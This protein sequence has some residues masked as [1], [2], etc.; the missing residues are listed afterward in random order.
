[1]SLLIG[2]RSHFSLFT[3]TLTH[4]PVTSATLPFFLHD[5]GKRCLH[6]KGY[7]LHLGSYLILKHF[8]HWFSHF[9]LQI[10]SSFYH[11]INS[12]EN[13][14]SS[15]SSLNHFLLSS[16]PFTTGRRK[17]PQNLL[18]LLSHLFA[19]QRT[20]IWSVFLLLD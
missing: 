2:A 9:C 19:L 18:S 4:R 20:E 3:V 14:L 8:L 15:V 6:T 1:M 11:P 12:N 17:S 7:F 16:L 13:S 10:C 5:L